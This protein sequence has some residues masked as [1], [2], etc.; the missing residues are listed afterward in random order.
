[1]QNHKEVLVPIKTAMVDV[2]ISSFVDFLNKFSSIE[3]LWSCEGIPWEETKRED[4]DG[5][6]DSD[7][8]SSCAYVSFTCDNMKELAAITDC[9]QKYSNGKEENRGYILYCFD[10]DPDIDKMQYQFIFEDMEV[11]DK[12]VNYYYSE[13]RPS[14]ISDV[15]ELL[16]SK[17]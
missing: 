13:Y 17:Q 1:M 8:R 15:E 4:I 11:P 14:V 3:T 6:L 12:I 7:E 16:P 5:H 2:G 10:Y 9:I